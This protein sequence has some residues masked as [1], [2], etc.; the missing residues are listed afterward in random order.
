LT[1]CFG[2]VII[3]PSID[4]IVDALDEVYL[5]ARI[6]IT[7]STSWGPNS[8][9]TVLAWRKAIGSA[10]ES[11]RIVHSVSDNTTPIVI[12]DLPDWYYESNA[13]LTNNVA[14]Y[15]A[16]ESKYAAKGHTTFQLTDVGSLD[17]YKLMKEIFIG[18]DTVGGHP[19][20]GMY[21]SYVVAVTDVC[22]FIKKKAT[23]KKNPQQK[24]MARGSVFFIA[25]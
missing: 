14:F 1:G 5:G 21:K 15:F 24:T 3:P 19:V 10:T 6:T 4:G 12:D 18:L 22:L 9:Q 2:I 25:L 17:E 16:E 13:P 20:D 11:K 7:P 8:P 23:I